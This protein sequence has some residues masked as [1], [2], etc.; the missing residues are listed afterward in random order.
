MKLAGGTLVPS[1]TSQAH[2]RTPVELPAPVHTPIIEG[3]VRKWLSDAWDLLS[4]CPVAWR[5]SW[6][7]LHAPE[8]SV[9]RKKNAEWADSIESLAN[10]DAA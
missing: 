8:L 9:V 4:E 10:E 5:R 1:K 7:D 2:Q 6:L 3:N